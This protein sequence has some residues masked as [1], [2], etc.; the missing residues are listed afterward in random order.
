MSP[1]ADEFRREVLERHFAKVR[2]E[3]LDASRARSRE[4][5]WVCL[6]FRED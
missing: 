4:Q 2:S 1:E 6:G 3:K 5:Y